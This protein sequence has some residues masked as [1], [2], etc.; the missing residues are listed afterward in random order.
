MTAY[1]NSA[2]HILLLRVES[3]VF[4]SQLYFYWKQMTW[5]KSSDGQV[6]Y[7]NQQ[8]E[9]SYIAFMLASDSPNTLDI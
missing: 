6:Q 3:A 7:R 5:F 1:V 9:K 4:A 8:P 2:A